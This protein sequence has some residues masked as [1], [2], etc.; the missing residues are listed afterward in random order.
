MNKG[1]E[2]LEDLKVTLSNISIGAYQ[3]VVEDISYIETAL[4]RLEEYE[5]KSTFVLFNGGRNNGKSN[6]VFNSFR[7]HQALEII[8]NKVVLIDVFLESEDVNDYNEFYAKSKD[9]HLTQEEYDLLKEV[10]LRIKNN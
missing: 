4:K 8:R 6:I 9:R 10:L 2:A 1:L 3:E 7:E 5:N